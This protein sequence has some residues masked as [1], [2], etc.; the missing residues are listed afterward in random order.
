M[1]HHFVE[2]IN[3]NADFTFYNLNCWLNQPQKSIEF[4]AGWLKNDFTILFLFVYNL[5]LQVPDPRFPFLGVHYTPR[6]NG[7]VWLGPNAVLAFK[8]EGYNLTDFNFKDT[9]D[10][11]SFRFVQQFNLYKLTIFNCIFIYIILVKVYAKKL[12]IV[13]LL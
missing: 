4:D 6:M 5:T 7:D 11:V 10:A 8:R 12:K 3:F 13:I 1:N 9:V 2:F